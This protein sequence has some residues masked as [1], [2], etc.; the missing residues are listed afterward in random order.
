MLRARM[1]AALALVS[2]GAAMPV[3]AEEAVNHGLG[4][5]VGVTGRT[6]GLGVEAGYRFSNYLGIR[7]TAATSPTTRTSI[8]TIS[9]RRQGRLK[10][11]GALVDIYPFAGSF[12]LSLGMRSNKNQFGGVA[13]PNGA[14]VEVGD[15]TYP[16]AACGRS[17]RYREIQEERA[18]CN[19]RLGRQLQDRAAFRLRG[20]PWSHRAARSC[21]RRA[22]V[23]W[24]TI[25][26][27][28]RASR[29][30]SRKWQDDSKDYKLWPV[31]QLNLVYRF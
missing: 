9:H 17:H 27:S 19:H 31:V 25:R 24:P 11:V 15:D 3:L 14:T 13:T 22:R 28:R 8:R 2:L 20:R 12:R 29:T 7:A 30:S 23:H 6:N 26:L 16:S 21:R 1:S 4:V 5:S 10:S 18:H